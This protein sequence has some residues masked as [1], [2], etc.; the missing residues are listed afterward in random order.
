MS[1]KRPA[2]P[3]KKKVASGAQASG[4]SSALKGYFSNHLKVSKLS[5][6][7]QTDRPVATLLTCSVIGIALVLPTLLMILLSN[8]HAANFDWDGS[9][10]ITLFLEQKVTSKEAVELTRK[11]ENRVDVS[12]IEFLDKDKALDDFKT[13]FQLE[14]VVDF[15]DQ[16]PLP[17]ALLVTPS[18][19]LKGV[20]AIEQ[21]M[22]QLEALPEVES[23]LLDALW[24][25]RLKSITSFLERV[26]VLIALMLALAVLLILGNTIRLAIE[27]RKE[28]IAV[29]K[30]V[31]GTRPFVCR[32][33]L[34][35]GMLYGLGGSLIAVILTHIVLAILYA[36]IEALALSYQSNF[37]LKGLGFDSTLL[38]IVFGTAL[39]WLGAWLAV[40]R[41]LDE[42][43]PT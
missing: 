39:G 37:N 6:K 27:N 24:I 2:S 43:E 35:M 12:R 32:P 5:F 36:P 42:I 20:P 41:H 25:Q 4:P 10:Q 30:L 34:Y 17:H 23:G 28:E 31:G 14:S 1:S 22:Q 7:E 18:S 33:F 3:V 21:L 15:L 8:I 13:Q 9:A 19:T 11:L 26:V 40:R 16:N 38:L 29:L